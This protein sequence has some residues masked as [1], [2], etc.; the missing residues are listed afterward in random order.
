VKSKVDDLRADKLYDD[1]NRDAERDS[2]D[3]NST[4]RHQYEFDREMEAWTAGIKPRSIRYDFV[5]GG[6]FDFG[7]SEVTDY[8]ND[9][10]ERLPSPVY[11]PSRAWPAQ[12]RRS[13]VFYD[14]SFY[15]VTVGF[16]VS[17][18]L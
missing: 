17:F 3:D 12:A 4:E 7:I 16:K 8:W 18:Y 2:M 9:Q 1:G 11:P 14:E 10:Y 15:V 5:A 6:P 13:E